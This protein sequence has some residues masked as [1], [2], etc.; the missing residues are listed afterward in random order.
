MWPFTDGY[1]IGCLKGTQCADI[2]AT[3]HIAVEK[4]LDCKSRG[5]IAQGDI[6]RFY[7]SIPCLRAIRDMVSHG[8]HAGTAVAT[9]RHQLMMCVWL[10]HDTS[11]IALPTRTVGALTG[12]RSAGAIGRYIVQ[13]TCAGMIGL[14]AQLRFRGP[15]RCIGILT[16]VDNLYFLGKSGQAAID[17]ML[18]FDECL[19]SA[20]GLQLKNG[21]QL[22]MQPRGST[23]LVAMPPGYSRV[24]IMP[25]LGHLIA[26]DGAIRPSWA[27]TRA[28][29]LRA[30]WKQVRGSR[31]ALA[32]EH[33]MQVI[34][35]AVRPVADWHF[36]VWPC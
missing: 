36:S 20:W 15:E 23:E 19:S 22:L 27:S 11:K 35:R 10:T 34:D 24:F 30:F 16:W 6:R 1:F 2:A 5:A 8:C 31:G 17:L 26:E 12:S 3:V 29:M 32:P 14:I 21:S 9:L 25:V 28:A 4:M 13:S 33:M 18:R 7:D